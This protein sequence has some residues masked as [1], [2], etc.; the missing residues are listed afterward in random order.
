MFWFVDALRGWA[1]G[2][3]RPDELAA[4]MVVARTLLLQHAKLVAEANAARE[5]IKRGRGGH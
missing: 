5:E 2:G 4:G 3:D 1:L